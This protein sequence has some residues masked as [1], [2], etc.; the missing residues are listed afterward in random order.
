MTERSEGPIGPMGDRAT[1]AGRPW[2]RR[3]V[4]GRAARLGAVAALAPVAAACAGAASSATPA[5]SAS[6]APPS[7]TA[8]ATAAPSE[9]PTATPAPTPEAELFIYNYADYIG[10]NVISDFEKKYGIKVTY[11][12]FDTYDTMTAK[13]GSGQ[14]G[15]DVTFATSTDVPGFLQRGLIQP[16]DASLI[17]NVV[18]LAPEWKD[19]SYDPG[20]AHSI[21]YMWWTT[22]VAYDTERIP[23][24]LTSWSALWDPRWKG[25]MSMLDDYREAFGAALI[26]LGKSVNTTSDADLDAALALLKEQKPLLRT[27]TTD[28]IGQLSSGDSWVVHSWGSDVYQVKADRPSV[29]YYIPSEGGIRGSDAMVLLANAKHPIAAQLFMDYMLDAQV[30]AAN[31][32][33]IG[34]MGPNQAA[35][36]FID[37]AILAD[38][39]VNPDKAVISTLQEI[40]DLGPDLEKYSTRWNELRAGG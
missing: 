11:D 39:A 30:S 16:L 3:Q 23:E 40:Q 4:L 25:H 18:N 8:A 10:E 33:F 28:D 17:P 38:P 26:R 37:P 15:Y 34:Y 19:P 7:A 6:A 22:G 1:G 35:K 29:T 27:Y 31:T 12:F 2:T 5:G 9:A 14:S 32:N 13:I 20:N 24:Q 21:P 36:E